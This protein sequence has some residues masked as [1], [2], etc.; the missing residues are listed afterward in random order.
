MRT[1]AALKADISRSMRVFMKE[2]KT[3]STSLK[4]VKANPRHH[5]RSTSSSYLSWSASPILSLMVDM[6]C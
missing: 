3:F 4:P 6:L 2:I 5:L 1:L